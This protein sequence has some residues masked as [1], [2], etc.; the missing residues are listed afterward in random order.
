M[1]MHRNQM[2]FK[3]H[4]KLYLNMVDVGLDKFYIELVENCSCENKEEL[5]TREGFFIREMGTL[6]S[7]IAG[8][9]KQDWTIEKHEHVVDHRKQYYEDNKDTIDKKHKECRDTHKVRK[10]LRCKSRVN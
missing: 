2:K 4:Y 8:R 10:I 7:C 6:N 9:S 1:A 3:P 5:R